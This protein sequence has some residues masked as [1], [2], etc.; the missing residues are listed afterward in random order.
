M[1]GTSNDLSILGRDWCSL[2]FFNWRFNRI[3]AKILKNHVLLTKKNNGGVQSKTYKNSRNL[4]KTG[5]TTKVSG[6]NDEFSSCFSHFCPPATPHSN[7]TTNP[8]TQC[9]LHVCD[10]GM[11]GRGDGK[12]ILKP[13]ELVS[14][15]FMKF[16]VPLRRKNGQT[17]KVSVIFVHLSQKPS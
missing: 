9:V 7:V 1:I 16:G 6:I 17:T 4:R 10:I 12:K 15:L 5:Q 11:G 8:D 13:I 14:F 2:F 3:S